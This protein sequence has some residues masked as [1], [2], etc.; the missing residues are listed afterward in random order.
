MKCPK[1]DFNMTLVWDYGDY[2]FCP[3]CHHIKKEI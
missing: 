2:E 1:C 3:N